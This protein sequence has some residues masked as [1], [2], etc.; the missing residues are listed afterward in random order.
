MFHD[1]EVEGVGQPVGIYGCRRERVGG[2]DV[3]F[4]AAEGAHETEVEGAGVVVE[5]FVAGGPGG[6]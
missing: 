5:D 3:C 1:G 2:G 4:S 6:G